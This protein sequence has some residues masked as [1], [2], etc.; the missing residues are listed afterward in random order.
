MNCPKCES[1]T[2]PNQKFC[3]SCGASLHLTTQPLA[4]HAAVSGLEKT[5]AILL[6][7]AKQRASSLA[8]RGFMIIFIG[9]AI[10][11]IGKMLMHEEIVTAIGV[12]VSLAGMFL[13]VY[14]SLSPSSPSRHDSSPSSQPEAPTQSRPVKYLPQES[15]IEYV[16]SITERT[17]GLLRQQEGE[18]S[19]S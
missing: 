17:T 5:P 13:T 1:Q 19:Q 3:R 2:V 10:G 7:N 18:E 16:P 15:K 14:P 6:K 4:E 9:V 8:L 12:L 11:V